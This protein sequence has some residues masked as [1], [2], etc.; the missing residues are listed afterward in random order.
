MPPPAL[1]LYPWCVLY[2]SCE[3][4]AHG[5]QQVDGS[6]VPVLVQGGN[7]HAAC[8]LKRHVATSPCSSRALFRLRCARVFAYC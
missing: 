2:N 3:T 6:R 1:P 7:V 5:V 4:T 8:Q